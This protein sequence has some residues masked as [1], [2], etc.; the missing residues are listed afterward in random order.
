MELLLNSAWALVAIISLC[1]WLRLDCRDAAE[2]RRS[3]VVI[4]ML[5]VIL[6]P[7]ISVSD[8]L[9]SIQN[10]AEENS[11]HRRDRLIASHH[12]ITPGIAFLPVSAMAEQ[13][14]VVRQISSL[15]VPSLGTVENLAFDA[16]ENRPPPR[17][18]A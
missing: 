2:R 16:I 5:V 7:V 4:L 3:F 6:F 8:D 13:I 9:W 18:A 15:L 1:L 10:P 12:S 11:L 17:L 14:V